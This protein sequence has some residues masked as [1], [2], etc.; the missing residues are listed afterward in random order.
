[1]LTAL[2]VL[3]VVGILTVVTHYV[4]NKTRSR[5]TAVKRAQLS[6]KPAYRLINKTLTSKEPKVF[7]EPLAG[8]MFTY[9]GKHSLGNDG[10]AVNGF[11]INDGSAGNPWVWLKTIHNVTDVNTWWNILGPE[12]IKKEIITVYQTYLSINHSELQVVDNAR[13]PTWMVQ[14]YRDK[15][16]E[17]LATTYLI[18]FNNHLIVLHSYPT[19]PEDHLQTILS[20][21]QESDSVKTTN[22]QLRTYDLSDQTL[23]IVTSPNQGFK[24]LPAKVTSI[25]DADL[26]EFTCTKYGTYSDELQ[27]IEPPTQLQLSDDFRDYQL[28]KQIAATIQRSYLRFYE[29]CTVASKPNTMYIFA[30][31][32]ANSDTSSNSIIPQAFAGGGSGVDTW[33]YEYNTQ[34][35]TLTELGFVPVQ[36]YAYWGCSNVLQITKSG[37]IYFMC[38]GGDG[39]APSNSSVYRLDTSPSNV[40]LLQSCTTENEYINNEYHSTTVCEP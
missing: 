31:A 16:Q 21:I 36:A 15:T 13:F 34:T 37:Q 23:E 3:V 30:S 22:Y 20:S 11:R 40:E 5:T 17:L 32:H 1:M 39:G 26:Q 6:G 38:G 7:T 4:A 33:I 25:S 19:S 29:R 12:L 9:P 2:V 10:S 18:Q 24:N 28:V 14:T 8:Y 27:M 35:K